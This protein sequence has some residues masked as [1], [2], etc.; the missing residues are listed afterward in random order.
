LVVDPG[1]SVRLGE[2][3]VIRGV[4]RVE[5]G[6][7]LSIGS[8]CYIGDGALISAGRD[9]AIGDDVLI[10]HDVNIFDNDTHPADA[11]ERRQHFSGMI[12]IAPS[13][14]VTIAAAPIR[15]GAGAWLGFGA[16]VMKGV[17]IG[18]RCVVAARAVVVDD[19]PADCVVAGN[20]ARVVRRAEDKTPA[21]GKGF[22]RKPRT[23]K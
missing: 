15:I 14:P 11:D 4:L 2:H 8:R 3:C 9:I 6:A 20:P 17:N 1:G 22:W 21:G 19:A 12:G 13:R 23:A 18:E 7:T 10:S 16:A 5:A